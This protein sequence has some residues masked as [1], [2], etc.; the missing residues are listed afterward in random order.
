MRRLVAL[1][2]VTALLVGMQAVSPAAACACGGVTPPTGEEAA[3]LGERAIVSLVDGIEQLDILMDMDSTTSHTGLIIPTPTPATVSVG[4]RGRFDALEEAMAP[5]PEYYDDWWGIES[6]LTGKAGVDD[7]AAPVVL[8]R[9]QIGDVVATSLAAGDS[10]GLTLWL[11]NNGFALPDGANAL[12]APYIA[13]NWSFVVVT[14]ASAAPEEGV[15]GPPLSG[16]VDPVRVTFATDRM[17]FPMRMSAQADVP[18]SV[19]FY[20]LADGPVAAVQA[21][22]PGRPINAAQRTVW[23]GELDPAL[24]EAGAFLTV[25]DVRFDSPVRQITDD[26]AFVATGA[27]D[28]M[29]P[30]YPAPRAVTLVGIPFGSLLVGWGVLGMLVLAGTLVARRRTR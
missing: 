28:T 17:V 22:E 19:R 2:I 12:F 6:L 8:D 14:L 18:V 23:A 11:G 15:A 24:G 21:K 4:D 5:R 25:T 13:D 3:V 30:S 27:N 9:V 1:G 10:A 16:T 26:V 29:I 20:V 7:P